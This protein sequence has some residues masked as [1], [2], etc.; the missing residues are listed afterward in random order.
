MNHRFRSGRPIP[1]MLIAA[2]AACLAGCGLVALPVRT[3]SAVVKVVP[4][5]GPVAATPV[6]AAADAID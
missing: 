3:A 2:M 1:L 6:D 4:V 5:V